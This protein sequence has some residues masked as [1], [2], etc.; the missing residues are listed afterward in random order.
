MLSLFQFILALL[1][2]YAG[3]YVGVLLGIN[4]PEELTPGRK[5]LDFGKQVFFVLIILSIIYV[6]KEQWMSLLLIFVT[7]IFFRI[8]HER[9]TFNLQEFY[10]TIAVITLMVSKSASAVFLLASLVFLYGITAGALLVEP[11][12]KHKTLLV[13]RR[14]LFFKA[15]NM[16]ADFISVLALVSLIFLFGTI[17]VF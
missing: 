11:H 17:K 10:I 8:V 5:F 6:L 3:L 14:Q 2:S 12:T 15:F 4:S 13:K 16:T 1:V 7:Y 9:W